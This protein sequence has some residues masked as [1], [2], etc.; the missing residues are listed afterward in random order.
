MIC[1]YTVFCTKCSISDRIFHQWVILSDYSL[2]W[3]KKSHFIIVIVI[4]A[5]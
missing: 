3:K 2:Q 1:L 5:C 4:M